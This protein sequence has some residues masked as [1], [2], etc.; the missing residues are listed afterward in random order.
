MEVPPQVTEQAFGY[1][2]RVAS[3]TDYMPKNRRPPG[4]PKRLPSAKPPAREHR[5]RTSKKPGPG[6]PTAARVD[7]INRAMLGAAKKEFGARSYEAARMERIAAT[8]GVSKGTLYDRYPTKQ[9]LLRA[10][11][12]DQVA[13]WSDH[14]DP[15]GGAVHADLGQRLKHRARGLME[16]LCEGRVEY[17]ERLLMSGPRVNELRH[18]NF[19]VGHGRTIQSI[20]QDIVLGDPDQPVEPT[21]ATAIAEMLLGMIYGWWRM[22]RDVRPVTH[23]EAV[24]FAD[25]AVDVLLKGRTAWTQTP[26]SEA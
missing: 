13:R 2:P 6:R 3:G 24:A 11:I 19:E 7:E 26:P 22:Y 21:V 16:S 5:D 10:V 17:I 4:T 1:D 20:A 14:W 12:A 9:E 25:H 15:V 18:M 23:Q 8:A